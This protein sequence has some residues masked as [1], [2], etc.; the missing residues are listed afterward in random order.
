MEGEAKEELKQG[1][2]GGTLL[3]ELLPLLAQ[4]AF[5]Y[6]AYPPAWGGI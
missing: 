4:L 5:S 6:N 3:T 2:L 1:D